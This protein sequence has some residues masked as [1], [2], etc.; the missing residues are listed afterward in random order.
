MPEPTMPPMTIMEASNRPSLRASVGRVDT[1]GNL[2]VASCRLP[3]VS[4]QA[5]GDLDI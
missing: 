1:R 2:S 3:V 4:N 5:T